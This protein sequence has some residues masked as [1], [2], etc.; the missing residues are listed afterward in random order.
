M[1]TIMCSELS[2]IPNTHIFASPSLRSISKV[3]ASPS[4]HVFI[5][6]VK[7]LPVLAHDCRRRVQTIN[8]ATCA[9]ALVRYPIGYSRQ[10]Q[11]ELQ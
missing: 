3:R 2:T 7:L 1:L 9:R 10:L 8:D 11:Q 6:V 5:S 4:N